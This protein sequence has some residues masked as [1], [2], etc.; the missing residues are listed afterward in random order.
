MTLFH[1]I[2]YTIGL[3]LVLGTASAHAEVVPVVSSRSALTSLSSREVADIF[4]GKL[5]RLN[6]DTVVPIDQAEGSQSRDEFYLKYADKSP[7]QVKA[8]WSKIIFTGRGKPPRDV[9]SHAEVKKHLAANP[10]AI[11][12]IDTRALDDSV[13]VLEVE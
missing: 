7:S 3:A 10:H 2:A 4:L 5:N 6:G 8:H 11:G 9:G 1:K 12:Y 13:R